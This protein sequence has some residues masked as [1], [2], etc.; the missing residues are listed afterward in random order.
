MKRLGGDILKGPEDD[1]AKSYW[2]LEFVQEIN[3]DSAKVKLPLLLG[4]VW[5]WLLYSLCIGIDTFCD[6]SGRDEELEICNIR[7]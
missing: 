6:L 3:T 1:C 4:K 2:L 7:L 5:L